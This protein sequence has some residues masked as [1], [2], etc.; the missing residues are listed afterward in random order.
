MCHHLG[1]S[2][3]PAH[4]RTI[5]C[6]STFGPRGPGL[7]KPTLFLAK[8]NMAYLSSLKR[9]QNCCCPHCRCHHLGYFVPPAHHRTIWCRSTFGPRGPG[10]SNCH[11]LLGLISQVTRKQIVLNVPSDRERTLF[12]P[13]RQPSDI[14][15]EFWQNW[16]YL[17]RA[18]GP[19]LSNLHLLP[20]ACSPAHR[21]ETFK[22]ITNEAS[23]PESDMKF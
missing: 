16:L 10:L 9:Q 11:L 23:L 8:L 6:R 17:I 13:A 1:Y 12:S 7:A 3:P 2:V 4:H 18:I 14:V 19:G 20:E 15:K 22:R 5:W 21:Y